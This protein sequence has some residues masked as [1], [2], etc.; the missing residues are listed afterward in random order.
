MTGVTS[1]FH[2]SRRKALFATMSEIAL[3]LLKNSLTRKCPKKNVAIGC[4][5][6]DFLG[7][8]R[9]FLSPNFRGFDENGVFQQPRLIYNSYC[10]FVK[11]GA[12]SRL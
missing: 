8:P 3:W 9:H 11:G 5:T 1:P 6:N 2:S 12:L 7:F 10:Q 4:P